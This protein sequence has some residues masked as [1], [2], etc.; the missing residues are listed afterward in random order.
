MSKNM[1]IVLNSA[2]AHMSEEEQPVE[3]DDKTHVRFYFN[4]DT[5]IDVSS[6]FELGPESP[7]LQVSSS[8]GS[9]MR[10]R[11]RAANSILTML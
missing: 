1:K 7:S 4:D 2:L 9:M 11:P 3:L 6:E 10:I 5:W 8:L